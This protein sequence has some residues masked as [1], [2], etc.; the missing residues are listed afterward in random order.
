MS[1]DSPRS[2]ELPRSRATVHGD[3]F[4]DD[5]AIGDEFTDC[6]AGVGVG[7]FVHFVRV[8]PDL[9]L[10]TPRDGGSETF[11]STKVDP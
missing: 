2:S 11:L 10:A 9:A 3:L 5:E 4:A 1:T 8:K 7:Y 6:L